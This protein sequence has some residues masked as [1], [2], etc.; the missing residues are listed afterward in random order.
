[1]AWLAAYTDGAGKRRFK[2]FPTKREA[3][4]FLTRAKTEVATGAHIPDRLAKTVDH[5]FGLLIAALEA[6]DAARS[7]I[8]NYRIYYDGHVRPFLGAHPLPRLHPAD[9]GDWLDRLRAEGRTEDTRRRARVVL[10]AIF[11][12]AIRRRLAHTNPVRFLRARRKTRRA[13]IREAEDAIR[14]PEREEVRGLLAAAGEVGSLWLYARTQAAGGSNVVSRRSDP[15]HPLKQLRAFAAELTDAKAYL[16]QPSPWLRPLI[17]TM[18]LAGL[19][20]GEARGLQWHR[21]KPGVIEVREA[22]DHS[23]ILDTVKTA[24]GLRDVP[25]GPQLEAILVDW[26]TASGRDSGLVFPSDAGTP[27]GYQ[28]ILNR[29]IGPLQIATGVLAKDGTPRWTPHSFRHFAVSLWID[30]G[31]SLKQVSA[32]AGH[33][34]PEF[35]SRVYGH[36]FRSGRTDRRAITA[37]EF[38]VLGPIADATETQHALAPPRKSN[39]TS[40]S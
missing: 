1:M 33:E 19:R 29:Q 32:K 24:A 39:A 14:I 30:E 5:A 13:E 4:T 23:N 26:R 6:D 3:D 9:V 15:A 37:G 12:E 27:L 7:T 22:V 10:G 21:I 16:F 8:R 17:A 25:I 20:I 31:E 35:T 40:G 36:L 38:S 2:Q 34:S 18:A 28:N 11:D